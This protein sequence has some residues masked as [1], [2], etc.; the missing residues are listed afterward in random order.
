M[1]IIEPDTSEVK[2]M[3]PLDPGVYP[4]EIT[5]CDFKESKAGN[6]MIVPV[7]S[8]TAPDGTTRQRRSYIVVT[9]NAAFTFDS[10]LRACGFEDYADELKA[11]SKT[12]FDTDSLI[13]L[14]VNV[15]VEQEAYNGKLIDTIKGYMK[16]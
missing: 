16:A 15:Q 8:I 3:M 2:E 11:G 6:P 14:C 12:P 10:F 5:A 4:A 9:G 1:P 13:G 7:F